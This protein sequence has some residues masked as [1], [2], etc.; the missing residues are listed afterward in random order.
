MLHRS[1]LEGEGKW[2]GKSNEGVKEDIIMEELFLAGKDNFA[3]W[4]SIYGLILVI[5]I[6]LSYITRYTIYMAIYPIVM[7]SPCISVYIATYS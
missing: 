5:N 6:A 1:N 4:T 2:D 3:S 7:C